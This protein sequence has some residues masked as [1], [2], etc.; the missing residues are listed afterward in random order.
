MITFSPSFF[1]SFAIAAVLCITAVT[2]PSA[3]AQSVRLKTMMRVFWQD[4]DTDQLSYA[5][6]TATD[7]W[8][9]KRGWIQGFPTLDA[10]KQDLVQMKDNNG[11]LLVGVR[12]HEDGAFQSGWVAVDTGVFEEPHGNHTHWKYT[13]VPK[14]TGMKLDADQGNPAHLYVYDNNFYLANDQKNGFSRL[15]PMLLKQAATASGSA[16]FFPGGGSHITMA[17]VNNQLVYSSWI[18]GGGP[19]AG[20]VD[21]VSLKQSGEPKIAY[22]FQLPSGVIH[23]ATHNSGKV[24]F[25]PA[26]GICW[27]SADLSLQKSAETIQVNHLPLG[28]DEDADK[29]LRTGAFVNEANWVLC[30]TG[31]GQQSKLCLLNA[32]SPQPSIVEVKIPVADG[33]KLTTPTTILSLGNRYALL[34]QG[35]TDGDSEI[36][37]QLTIVELDPNRN[38]DFSDARVKTSIPIG[39]SKVDGH[40]GHHAISFDAYGRFAVFT[41]P[42][43]G[44]LNVFSMKDMRVVARFKVG[45]TPDSIVAV[46]APEHFH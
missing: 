32:A 17:A 13:G 4:R 42:G 27:V 10:D 29:A 12:D 1:T 8:G 7:K 31:K 9:I 24:F 3:D 30:T 2:A 35:R 26:D 5:D 38:R 18:D 15:Q 45:G 36:Q 21:V 41:E 44:I 11:M 43:E 14:V 25:A 34:F 39:A 19:N 6:I 16:K 28:Q 23:G 33:L 46:G 22:S 37:E 40:H 20:R